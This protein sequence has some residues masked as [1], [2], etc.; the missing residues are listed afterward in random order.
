M[1]VRLFLL[2]SVSAAFLAASAALPGAA[3]A[4]TPLPSAQLASEAYKALAAGDPAS[5]VESYSRAIESRELEPEVLANAL[6]NRALAY[7][8]LKQDDLAV[9]DYSAAM[10]IDA[11]SAKLRA[12]A[13]YN[14][15]LS[16]QKLEQPARAIEDYTS[17][18][19]L[20]QGFAHAYY[21]RGNLLREQGQMLFALTDFE[22]AIQFNHPDP[23]RVYYGEAL[24]YEGLNRQSNARDALAK[25]LAANPGFRPA[26]DKMAA[27]QGGAVEPA[28]DQITTSALSAA[29]EIA[30][31]EAL[32]EASPPPAGLL[33][34]DPSAT[35]TVEAA[36][37]PK[38]I[39]DRV[40]VS[41]VTDVVVADAAAQ[42]DQ[43]PP[44]E[45]I[46]AIEPVP[47]KPAAEP[48]AQVTEAA[49]APTAEPA[50]PPITGW[51]VQVASATSEDAAWSTWKKMQAAHRVLSGRQPVVVKADL[52]TK[53]TFFRVR[54]TGF[55]NQND[56]RS[57]CSKLKS[58]GVNCFIS[59]A[60]S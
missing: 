24:A 29:P 23:A 13:L 48:E 14:R 11:M 59:K 3:Q 44:E 49:A 53:G 2:A 12:M 60:S 39:V 7:Q 35:S 4:A 32:P 43:P 50:A 21:S 40:P 54:L 38:K 57:A 19:F 47:A 37:P 17:A 55:D 28:A 16:Y 6:L 33:A 26:L 1:S 9:A 45:K 41:D 58:G 18:L 25:S 5:A 27:L 31:K 42:P 52:G 8:Y 20:D 22:K 30:K 46:I 36:P 15:G 10:R 51:T 34:D 56:A